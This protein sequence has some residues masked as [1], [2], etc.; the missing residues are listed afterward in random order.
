MTD[1]S[2]S[3]ARDGR[4]RIRGLLARYVRPGGLAVGQ[5]SAAL[6]GLDET[7][8]RPNG[9]VRHSVAPDCWRRG[10]PGAHVTAVFGRQAGRLLAGRVVGKEY[11][12]S[13]GAFLTND[14]ARFELVTGCDPRGGDDAEYGSR[15]LDNGR[16]EP[17][18]AVWAVSTD[19]LRSE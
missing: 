17:I 1:A 7:P 13:V 6:R 18:S 16:S 12:R 19:T 9:F 8:R 10:D 5:I 4:V 11:V 15:A 2:R 14:L 3:V